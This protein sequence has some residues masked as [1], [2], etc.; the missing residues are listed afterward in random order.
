MCFIIKKKKKAVLWLNYMCPHS[1]GEINIH[2]KDNPNLWVK[3]KTQL[4]LSNVSF[5]ICMPNDIIVIHK[6]SRLNYN[7]QIYKKNQEQRL[8]KLLVNSGKN[9]L[10]NLI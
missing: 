6:F 7:A 5:W 3:A 10:H 2:Q 9:S 8:E 4:K 1:T